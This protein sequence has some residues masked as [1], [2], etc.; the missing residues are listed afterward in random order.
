MNL[1]KICKDEF[2]SYFDKKIKIVALIAVI[3]I[4]LLYSFLYLKAYW[5]P[6]GSL[7]NY[8][9]AIVNNDNGATLDDK[10]KNYGKDLVKK[11]KKNDDVGF[12][13]VDRNTAENGINNNKYFAVIEIPSDFSEKIVNAK[14]GQ[15]IAP[16]IKYVSNNKKNYIGTKISESVKEKILNKLKKSVSKEYGKTAFKTVYELRDGLKDASKGTDKLVDGTEKIIKGTGTF[17]TGTNSFK[18]GNVKLA[19]G[20][21]KLN[22]NVPKL[23]SG[24][25]KLYKGSKDLS[26]GLNSLKNQVP[27]LK[28]GVDKLYNGSEEL[29]DG[30]DQLNGGIDQLAVGVNKLYDGYENTLLPSVEKLQKG[31]S[32]L[33]SSLNE[34]D[35]GASRLNDPAGQLIEKS[36][37]LNDNTKKLTDSVSQSSAAMTSVGQYIMTAAKT[38]PE[39][40]KDPNVQKA[41]QTLQGLQKNSADQGTQLKAYADGVDTYTKGVSEFAGNVQKTTSYIDKAAKGSSKLDKGMKKLNDGMKTKNSGSFRNGL[42][43]LKKSMTTLQKGTGSLKKGSKALN[44]GI[45]RLDDKLPALSDGVGKLYNGSGQLSNGLSTL[46]N[47]VPALGTGI[48]KLVDGS[49]QLVSGSKKLAD[50][51]KKLNSSMK[52]LKNGENKLKKGLDKGVDKVNDNVKSSSSDLG[53]FIGNPVHVKDTNINPVNNYGSG[54][55]PYFLPISLWIGAVIMLLILKIKISEYKEM[56]NLELTVGKYIP[57]AIIGIIQALALG[58]IVLLLGIKPASTLLLFGFLIVSALA[59]DAIIYNFINLFGIAG[60]A[61]AI[62]LLVLQLCSDA[63]TFPIETLPK[64]FRGINP[65][66]PFTY[67]V[68]GI[69][70]VLYAANINMSIV[71]KDTLITLIF[72]LVSMVISVIFIRKGERVN[73]YIDKN[74]AA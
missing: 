27:S 71:A 48:K 31:T 45:K 51:S 16:V 47:Q 19:N 21:D 1:F 39:V 62:V 38:N 61:I 49:N 14:D 20:L 59:F 65:F 15:A 26:S 40:A 58:A 30:A 60:E 7:K 22:S 44:G 2:K 66:L 37:D 32:E 25:K 50:G 74:L 11:L 10:K 73:E 63:G 23:S 57:Y 52:K 72:G 69:R 36:K 70:E 34:L 53:N 18:D 6:Y 12:K 33:S 67:T 55:A 24:V 56:N 64:F 5:D 35:K 29:A 68:E 8:T 54:L 42:S 41:L 17:V 3:A 4:P 28:T 46:N 43:T 13:F 9:V